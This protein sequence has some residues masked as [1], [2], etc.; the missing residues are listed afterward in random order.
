MDVHHKDKELVQRIG[1]WS[2]TDTFPDWFLWWRAIWSANK[3]Y[4]FYNILKTFRPCFNQ[5][6]L[7]DGQRQ[8][9]QIRA[10]ANHDGRDDYFE[11]TETDAGDSIY[12]DDSDDSD[13]NDD[14]DDDDDIV[15]QT[16]GDRD[17]KK[18]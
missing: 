4:V 7:N 17:K 12:D 13:D 10:W 9:N 15:S 2:I 5:A 8:Q 14:N 6:N 11:K 18:N 1:P 16:G 3:I